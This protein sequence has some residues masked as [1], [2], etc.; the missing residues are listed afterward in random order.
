LAAKINHVPKG[1]LFFFDG[2]IIPQNRRELTKPR[3]LSS[4]KGLCGGDV[5]RQGVLQGAFS[6]VISNELS[7]PKALQGGASGVVS[8]TKEHLHFLW[9]ARRELGGR[10]AGDAL[11]QFLPGAR[12]SQV[13]KGKGP[14]FSSP[15]AIN[16]G[17]G[18][19]RELQDLQSPHH[20]SQVVGVDASGIIRVSLGQ[21]PVEGFSAFFLSLLLQMGAKVPVPG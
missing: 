2:K 21:S 16:L 9:K 7:I 11:V 19:S 12:Q 17:G 20:P 18:F 15:F 10:S 8:S 5:S 13:G 3:H 6:P 1:F 4:R 14:L